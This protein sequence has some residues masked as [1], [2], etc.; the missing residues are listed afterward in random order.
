MFHKEGTK[1]ILFGLILQPHIIIIWLFYCYHV[2]TE[3]T[4]N[5]CL[6]DISNHLTIFRNPKKFYN[7]ENQIL[8]DGKVVVIEECTEGEYYKDKRLQISIFMSY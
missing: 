6:F 3:A 7:N 8:V 2:V 1:T 5:W 4:S